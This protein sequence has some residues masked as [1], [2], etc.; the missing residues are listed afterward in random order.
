MVILVLLTPMAVKEKIF[1]QLKGSIRSENLLI[2]Q[3]RIYKH[4]QQYTYH[5]Q[6]E[7]RLNG[8]V[9]IPDSITFN[10]ACPACHYPKMILYEGG[11]IRDGKRIN[12]KIYARCNRCDFTCSNKE[13]DIVKPSGIPTLKTIFDNLKKE[14]NN[15]Y[16]A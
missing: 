16:K 7:A 11:P 4:N 12:R 13:F 6:T 15:G 5:Y 1:K 10:Q 8:L 3:R 2:M 9:T 14:H